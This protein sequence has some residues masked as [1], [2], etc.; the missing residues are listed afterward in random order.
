MN[1][2]ILSLFIG[3]I[4]GLAVGAA[5]AGLFSLADQSMSNIMFGAM[6]PVGAFFGLLVSIPVYNKRKQDKKQEAKNFSE[7][8]D[9]RI[10]YNLQTT[11]IIALRDLKFIVDEP[12]QRI[13]IMDYSTGYWRWWNYGLIAGCE[14][15]I[16]GTVSQTTGGLK[17]A[18][19]GYVVAGGIGAVVGA[20]TARRTTITENTSCELIMYFD[21]VEHPLEK[22]NLSGQEGIDFADEVCATIKAIMN[23][24]K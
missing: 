21:S 24:K 12:N 14:V 6:L 9:A 19:A 11:K 8:I 5:I 4:L 15:R 20:A 18:V 13:W 3:A 1:G 16:D 17:N 7:I 2:R 22:I 23:T 10:K